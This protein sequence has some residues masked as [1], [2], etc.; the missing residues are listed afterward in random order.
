ML[1]KTMIALFTVASI[2]M[3]APSFISAQTSLTSARSGIGAF[4]T[5]PRTSRGSSGKAAIRS[6]AIETTFKTQLRPVV[7]DCR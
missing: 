5:Q 7:L 1:R 4:G 6:L 3:L 2:G